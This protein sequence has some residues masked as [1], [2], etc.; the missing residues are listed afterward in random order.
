MGISSP[1]PVQEACIPEILAERD[2]IA[3]AE[4][5]TGKTA[6]CVVPM[7][8]TLADDPYGICGLILTDTRELDF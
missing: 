2:V 4:T 6:A 5:G 1:T 8:E 7:L 3:S